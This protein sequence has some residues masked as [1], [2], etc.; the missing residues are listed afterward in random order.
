MKFG[1][2][3][4]STKSIQHLIDY[5][6]KAEELE[7]DFF[8]M[9]E[10][11]NTRDALLCASMIAKE[12]GKISVGAMAINPYL[13]H[14]VHIAT[15]AFSFNEI[16][17]YK[18]FVGI[19]ASGGY[20]LSSVGLRQIRPVNAVMETIDIIKKLP[21]YQPLNY[22]GKFVHLKNFQV[23]WAKPIKVFACVNGPK[24]L[25]AAGEIADGAILAHMPPEYAKT[26]YASVKKGLDKSG[27]DID[28]EFGVQPLCFMDEDRE[29]ALQI[30]RKWCWFLQAPAL[31]IP[32]ALELSGFT[33]NEA[34]LIR[35]EAGFKVTSRKIPPK[36]IDK[37][38]TKF[39]LTGTPEDLIKKIEQYEAAGVKQIILGFPEAD[40]RKSLLKFKEQII[41]NF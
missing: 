24:M 3:S 39:A 30:A 27:R 40:P 1:V 25:E 8:W 16:A 4:I 34:N 38:V 23:P 18:G 29:K 21:Q 15:S 32:N 28:F 37:I 33:I 17:R 20:G 6:K 36:L 14:P 41:N 12:T 9:F 31:H 5:A 13:R 2:G 35:K 19:G 10:E 7:F 11:T 22:N 26:A